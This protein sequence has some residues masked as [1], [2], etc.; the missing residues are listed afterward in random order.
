MK[1]KYTLSVQ[2]ARSINPNS[3]SEAVIARK[4]TSLKNEQLIEA[5]E[6][7]K[8]RGVRGQCALKSG[9]FPMVKDRDHKPSPRKTK[10]LSCLSWPTYRI[11][12]PQKQPC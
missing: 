6:W 10:K 8:E 1:P 11:S 3:K 12:G 2:Q 4:H 9:L 5:V 7:C